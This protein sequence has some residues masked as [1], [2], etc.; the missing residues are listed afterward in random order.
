MDLWAPTFNSFSKNLAKMET[1][2]RQVLKDSYI[3]RS[4][5]IEKIALLFPWQFESFKCFRK[6]WPV[7]FYLLCLYRW[8]RLIRDKRDLV[9]DTKGSWGM[10]GIYIW[11]CWAG[12]WILLYLPLQWARM[13]WKTH[14]YTLFF[15][16]IGKIRCE[17]AG[18]DWPKS[19]LPDG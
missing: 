3:S 7:L 6:F 12:G 9:K 5:R 14:K 13:Y 1:G 18:R 17:A 19:S 10:T 4:P 16:P 8:I 2:R 11:V 15:C